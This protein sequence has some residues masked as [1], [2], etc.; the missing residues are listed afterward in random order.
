MRDLVEYLWRIRHDLVLSLTCPI[1]SASR[2]PWR[3]RFFVS[4]AWCTCAIAIGAHRSLT[5]KKSGAKYLISSTF[6][7]RV[8]R[9]VSTGAW[10]PLSLLA[11]PISMAAAIEIINEGCT[12]GSGFYPDKALGVWRLD[13]LC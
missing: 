11:S 6:S 3:V 8:N 5:L 9:D 4:T 13:Q 12:E 7:P 10:R 1:S 2:Y